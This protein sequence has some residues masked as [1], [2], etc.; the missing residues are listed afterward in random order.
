[1]HRAAGKCEGE[2]CGVLFGL[3]FHFDH[4]IADG[5]G[6]EPTLENCAVLCHVCHNEKTRKH[7]VPLIAKVKRISDKHN[8]IIG[9]KQKFKSRG[10]A[11]RPA[12]R[13]ASRPIERRT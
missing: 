13:T 4:I 9:P 8:G 11:K 7:D 1:L 6:G 3:K 5:L 12:Q 2:N 10:F